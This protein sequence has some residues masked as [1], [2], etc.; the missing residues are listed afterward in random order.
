[1]LTGTDP[2]IIGTRVKCWRK[3]VWIW[4]PVNGKSPPKLQGGVGGFGPVRS[5][6]RCCVF[7]PEVELRLYVNLFFL[8]AFCYPF[9]SPFFE[10]QAMTPPTVPF[11]YRPLPDQSLPRLLRTLRH[12][13]LFPPCWTL[14][15][16]ASPP[17]HLLLRF[18]ALTKDHI[19]AGLPPSVPSSIRDIGFPLGSHSGRNSNF[20]ANLCRGGRFC[21]PL[22]ANHQIDS[23]QI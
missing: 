3:S 4:F 9:A 12:N 6:T 8:S 16:T 17:H 14:E 19:L 15:H 5:I 7:L 10:S 11:R 20:P 23:P 21:F 18:P 13:R 1:M 22:A 2:A